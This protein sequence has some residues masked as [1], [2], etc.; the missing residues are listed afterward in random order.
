MDEITEEDI[1]NWLGEDRGDKCPRCNSIVWTD[2]LGTKWCDSAKCNWSNE[3]QFEQEL[4]SFW[5][6]KSE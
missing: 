3:A 6:Q 1:N 5:N 4:K 2:K